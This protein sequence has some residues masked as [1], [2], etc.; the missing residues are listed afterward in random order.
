M[1]VGMITCWYKNLSMANYAYNLCAALGDQVKVKIVTSHCMCWERFIKRKEVFQGECELASFPPYLFVAENPQSPIIFRL[2]LYLFM[3]ALQFLRGITYLSKCKDCDIIHYQ[4]TA[5]YS[6]G[7]VPLCMILL[8]PTQ[9][10][11][12]VTVH[13]LDMLSKRKFFNRLYKN[14][15]CIIVH[16]KEMRKKML[17]LGIAASKVRLIPHGAQLPP[18]TKVPRRYITFFGAPRENKGFLTILQALKILK[19][20]GRKIFLHIYGIYSEAEKEMAIKEATDLGVSDQLIWGGKLSEVEFDHKMQESILTLAPYLGTV[21]GSSIIT[22]AMGNA[23]PIIASNI[24]GI[25]EY[26][27]N[28]GLLI[29]PNDARALAS[30][31]VRLLDDASLRQKLS[32]ECRKKARAFSWK[33][34]GKMTLKVYYECK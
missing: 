16:S 25:P 31:I 17:A 9:K 10:K 18:L 20:E 33:T 4:Q 11:R 34:V 14:A 15:D 7:M 6:F 27:G 28:A 5:A 19:D 23:T 2:L 29:P 3:S 32:E 30:A 22:R 1:K 26:L 12:I 13:R 8:I 21:S 24:G